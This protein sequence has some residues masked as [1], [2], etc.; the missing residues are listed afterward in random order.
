[1]MTSHQTRGA[2]ERLYLEVSYAEKDET[3]RLLGVIRGFGSSPLR[4]AAALT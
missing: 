2:G 4:V 1:M 3:N